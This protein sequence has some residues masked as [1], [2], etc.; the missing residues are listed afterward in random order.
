M[1]SRRSAGIVLF[2]R[3]GGGLEVLLGH[4]GGPLW[5]RRDEG[6]WTIPKGEYGDDEDALAAARREF[7]EELG[8]PVP[9]GELISLG[10]V[11]QA[12]GKVVTVWALEAELD[13]ASI[14]P[15]TFELQ[16]PPRSGRVQRFPEL[17]RVGWFDLE[18][19][20]VKLVGAQREFL[21]RLA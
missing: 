19:A 6:A 13:P 9:A 1:A 11:R 21:D 7:V 12:G 5:A 8:V 14:T 18:T 20:T 4:L 2:R 16:W 17:D 3:T 15:G 10:A